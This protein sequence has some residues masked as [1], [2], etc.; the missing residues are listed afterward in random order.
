LRSRSGEGVEGREKVASEWGEMQ[1]ERRRH[2]GEENSLEADGAGGVGCRVKG[3]DKG[4]AKQVNAGGVCR[5]VDSDDDAAGDRREVPRVGSRLVVDQV[6][7]SELLD[8]PCRGGGKA[9][10]RLNA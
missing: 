5:H 6:A 3:R 7:P 8:L 1:E 9:A 2:G 4:A 10:R